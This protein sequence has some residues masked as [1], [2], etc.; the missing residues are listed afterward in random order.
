MRR[1]LPFLL[2]LML[3]IVSVTPAHADE[4]LQVFYAGR[5]GG[6]KT[7][8]ELAEFKLVTDPSQA[9]VFVLNGIIPDMDILPYLEDGAGLLLILGADMTTEQVGSLL[10]IPL[11]ITLREDAVSLTNLD[12]DDPL[13]TEIVWNGAPQVRER[14]NVQTPVSSVQP[15]VTAYED[16]EWI[17]WQAKP[18]AFVFTV[19]LDGANPQIQEWAYFNYLIY[20]LVERAAGRTPLSFATIL[21]PR[22]RTRRSGT[23]SG[24]SW[25]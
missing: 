4:S 16:G 25:V 20:H 22:Y 8:L 6:V 21:I 3:V 11:E 18:N 15:L 2:A 19:F 5:D 10:G 13:I 17:L 24:S 14:F 7:A 9:D 23:C 12:L 1:L